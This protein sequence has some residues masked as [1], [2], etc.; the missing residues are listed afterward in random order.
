[1][2]QQIHILLLSIAALGLTFC[3]SSEKEKSSVS[4]KKPAAE[5]VKQ[6][7]L[8]PVRVDSFKLAIYRPSTGVQFYNDGILFLSPSKNQERMIPD[9]ISFGTIEAY[10]TPGVDAIPEIS[11]LFSPS[12]LFN[13]PCEAVTF[14]ADYK[15][16]YYTKITRKEPKEKIY[17]A[18]YEGEGKK[19][20]GWISE[21]SPVE[22]CLS[23]QVYSHP[24]LSPDGNMMVFASD[25]GGGSGKMDLYISRMEADKWSSPQNLGN[26]I[27]TSGNEF[28]PFIDNNNNLFFSSDGHK[29]YGGYDI[30]VSRFNGKNW[31]FAVNLSS[32]INSS[33]DDVAFTMDKK[34]STIAFYSTINKQD[35]NIQLFRVTP[36]TGQLTVTMKGLADLLY[37]I[38]LSD[39]TFTYNIPV[40][41]TA[42]KEPPITQ[43]EKKVEAKPVKAVAPAVAVAEKGKTEPVT[44]AAKSDVV[45][46]RVQI[47]SNVKPRGSTVYK[48][49]GVDYKTYEYLYNGAYRSTIG[50]FNSYKPALD[51][52]NEL[53]RSGV[54]DAFVVAFKNNV[55]TLDTSLF[56]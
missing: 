32:A 38:G 51:L 17:K 3:A 37:N 24:A 50:E 12:S 25:M 23:G 48:F 29:G 42:V 4:E 47:I 56:K 11:T 53:R 19:K 18:T 54:K 2:N 39:K 31:E 8:M 41:Q 15:T 26:I 6:T 44:A 10:Y 28:Y 34:T 33:K 22:F 45:V 1:M 5:T 36:A 9:H 52:Q 49:K 46:Y 55:R 7:D 16:M 35:N 20:A 27:N 30:F 40:A 14:T 13:Y 21:D 43:P